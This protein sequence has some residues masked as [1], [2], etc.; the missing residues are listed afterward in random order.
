MDSFF[1]IWARRFIM[2][3]VPITLV[4]LEWN[5]PS[6][7]SKNVYA[8][9]MH[10]SGWWKNL[11]IIQSFL[12]GAVAVGAV[13]LTLGN[14]SLFG[15]LS[16][17]FIWI[18]AVSYLVFDSTAG[19]A[20]GFILDMPNKSPDVDVESVKKIVQALYNDPITGGSNS[21]F[22]LLG[23]Y[24][25]LFGIF[26]AIIAI[27]M[28]N[29]GLAL[30]KLLPP[31]IFLGISAYALCVGHYAPYGPIAF[32]SFAIASIWFEYFDFGPARPYKK[33]I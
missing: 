18:F 29:R 6:G 20:V 27:F 14:N 13:F 21:F 25:W 11:H 15:T 9:L 1:W 33:F 3:A 22:S 12:F 28:A 19:I 16:K 32:F 4:I 24:S 8:G 17:V 2:I 5:H 26:S 7:F 30:A 10:M 31:L 23:S